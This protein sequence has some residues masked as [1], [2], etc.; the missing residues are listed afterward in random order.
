ML[1][2]QFDFIYFKMWFRVCIAT[3]N[4][5]H[6]ICSICMT[7]LHD[8]FAFSLKLYTLKKL[9]YTLPYCS[10][11]PSPNLFVR[12]QNGRQPDTVLSFLNCP[13]HWF[14]LLFSLLKLGLK[15]TMVNLVMEPWLVYYII[16]MLWVTYHQCFELVIGL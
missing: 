2:G 4:M 1:Q 13:C 10:H 3:L 7:Y 8:L 16:S 6:M 9:G 5:N 15:F 11:L 12:V 14:P